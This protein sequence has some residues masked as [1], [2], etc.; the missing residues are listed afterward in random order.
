MGNDR[1]T[2]TIMLGFE[3]SALVLLAAYLRGR[4]LALISGKTMWAWLTA[5]PWKRLVPAS[6]LISLLGTLPP[7]WIAAS[8][9]SHPRSSNLATNTD[10]RDPTNADTRPPPP[11]PAVSLNDSSHIRF[12]GVT[13]NGRFD[14]TRSQHINVENS[15][16]NAI[17][18]KPDEQT[19]AKP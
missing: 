9:W 1:M 10:H 5:R 18:Q 19:P 7:A 13:V 6:L 16:L 15:T 3:A 12:H 4:P 11:D 14:A 8:P 17:P 2:W